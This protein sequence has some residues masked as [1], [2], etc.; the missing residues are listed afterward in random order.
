MA[1]QQIGIQ[2]ND[3]TQDEALWKLATTCV[4]VVAAW[5]ENEATL[6]Q[7]EAVAVISYVC[8]ILVSPADGSGEIAWRADSHGWRE[9][10]CGW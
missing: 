2:G 8:N 1:E 10:A 9:A 4:E 7:D 6:L 5:T 3:A